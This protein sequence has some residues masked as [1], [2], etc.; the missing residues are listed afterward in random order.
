M[1]G[2]LRFPAVETRNVCTSAAC[3][4][5]QPM[6]GTSQQTVAILLLAVVFLPTAGALLGRL[7][8]KWL[9]PRVLQV[10]AALGFVGALTSAV[11]LHQ[12]PVDRSSLGALAIF[13]PAEGPLID[14]DAFDLSRPPPGEAVEPQVAL[15]ATT[16][17]ETP[18][19]DTPTPELTEVAAAVPTPTLRVATPVT[20]ARTSTPTSRPIATAAPTPTVEPTAEPTPQPTT[21][22]PTSPPP[23]PTPAGDEPEVYFVREGDTLRSIAERFN[24]SV[25]ALLRYNGLSAEEGDELQLDQRLLIPPLRAAAPEP[26]RPPAPQPRAYTVQEGDTLRGIAERF[27]ISVDAL[28]RYNG[29]SAEEGDQLRPEQRLFIPPR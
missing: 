10:V 6:I 7:L 4:N 26:A 14:A 23:T 28:L 3:Y 18:T 16:P 24:V 25:D 1:P 20:P 29:L 17:T 22:P 8:G 19:L 13:I 2:G 11:V 5:G 12:S 21:P 15:L 27:D 9:G